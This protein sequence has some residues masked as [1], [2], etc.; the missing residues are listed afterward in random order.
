MSD[1]GRARRMLEITLLGA[2]L[3]ASVLVA[4]VVAPAAFAVLPSRALA[5][6]LVGRVLPAIFISG[7]T[8]A[9]I[10][11]AAGWVSRPRI[12]WPRALAL[13]AIT[14]A[15]AVAQFV[16]TP[17]IARLREAIGGAIEA[18]PANDERRAAFGQL[19]GVSVGLLGL[20]MIGALIVVCLDIA[21]RPPSSTSHAA[22]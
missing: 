11:L 3:G 20:A 21:R 19:H 6:V 15:C 22:G 5:A 13:G 16:V 7:S 1:D 14:V 18:L 10:L 17:R 8:L 2:W 9:L 4:T 12:R